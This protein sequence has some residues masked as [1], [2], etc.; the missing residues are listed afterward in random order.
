MCRVCVSCCR[1]VRCT[2]YD[3]CCVLCFVFRSSV[4]EHKTER[5]VWRPKHAT[6]TRA[7]LLGLLNP[8]V[9]VTEPRVC[10][11]SP[12]ISAS[13]TARGCVLGAI[14]P[15]SLLPRRP[16]YYYPLSHPHPHH[17]LLPER[18]LA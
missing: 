11:L 4:C 12:F 2:W 5:N 18:H 6:T 14:F 1:V 7:P 15:S 10:F 3:I 9:K 13:N 16:H 8:L 17:R